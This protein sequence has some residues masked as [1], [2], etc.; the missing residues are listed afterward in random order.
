MPA[1]RLFQPMSASNPTLT[2]EFDGQPL[3]VLAG[4]SLA[5]ALLASGVRSTR[6]SVVSASPRA[7]FCMMG[8]CFE[9]LVEV[10]GQASCQA[11]LL[12]VRE[13]MRV[14]SQHGVRAVSTTE[15]AD[16]ES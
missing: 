9:C 4:V 3:R 16:D 1:D 12:P 14:R 6:S 10:D 11:C 7:P 5:A 2:I 8:V 13:G 15:G